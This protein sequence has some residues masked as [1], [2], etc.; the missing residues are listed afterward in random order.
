[1]IALSRS[2]YSAMRVRYCCT[3]SRD[4]T[5]AA[6]SAALHLRD[7]RFDDREARRLSADDHRQRNESH[8]DR[9]H[10]SGH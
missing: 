9:K 1:M 8:G 7:R 6:A 4:V 5:R 3:S 2:S 10:S